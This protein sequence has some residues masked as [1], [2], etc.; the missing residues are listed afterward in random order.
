MAFNYYDGEGKPLDDKRLTLS[1]T[2]PAGKQSYRIWHDGQQILVPRGQSITKP[3]SPENVAANTMVF[4]DI[5]KGYFQSPVVEF[6]NTTDF[7]LFD[8]FKLS[9]Y[10][11]ELPDD[12]DTDL[13][14]LGFYLL[15]MQFT[16][17]INWHTYQWEIPKSV[18]FIKVGTNLFQTVDAYSIT[19]YTP[20]SSQGLQEYNMEINTFFNIDIAETA[21]LG[22]LPF[23]GHKLHMGLQNLRINRGSSEY[24][25]NPLF[26]RTL[27]NITFSATNI[28]VLRGWG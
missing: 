27:P 7:K 22:E 14:T 3:K 8:R 12:P 16:L 9:I 21:E 11:D 23:G 25:Y 18:T 24:L 2:T 1:G 13:E 4:G 28:K 17:V 5:N 10:R 26:N 15:D 19:T 20:Y 6:R